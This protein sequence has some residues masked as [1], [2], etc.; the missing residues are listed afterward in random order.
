MEIASPQIR[1]KRDSEVTLDPAGKPV[2]SPKKNLWL[3]FLKSQGASLAA[4]GVD[5]GTLVGL[6]ELFKVW[7]VAATFLGAVGGAITNFLLGRYW[8]FE[9]S[10][11]SSG[12]QAKR[13]AIVAA[14]S[15]LLNSGFVYLVTE[16]GK[17]NY[18]ISKAVVAFVIGVIY[19]FPMQRR[20][21]F[22]Q[23]LKP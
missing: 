23:G 2:V 19:N 20:F 12:P 1:L 3:T 17:V 6:V 11:S 22:R 4:T 7:Y 18:A 15:A 9:A 5:F 10:D 14:G 13:Y 16:Y 8:T 21:V